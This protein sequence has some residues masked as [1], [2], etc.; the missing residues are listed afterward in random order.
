M[1][2]LRL[3]ELLYPLGMMENF[4]ASSILEMK[5]I[6]QD[7]NAKEERLKVCA[8]GIQRGKSPDF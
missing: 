6:D 2:P 1:I 7:G 8:Q 4:E 5:L 3:I